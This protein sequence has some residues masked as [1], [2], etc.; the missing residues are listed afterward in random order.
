MSRRD[1][2][3]VCLVV[4]GLAQ[5]VGDLA[6]VPALKGLAAATCASPAPKVFSSVRGLETF[7]T[8]FTLEWDEPDGRPGA[9]VLTPEVYARLAGPYNRRNVYG[10]VLAYGP[11]LA[12]EPRTRP[13]FDAVLQHALCGA[14]PLATELGLDPARLHTHVRLLYEPRPGSD[15]GGLPRVLEACSR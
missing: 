1:F 3:A 14:R 12:T 15:M 6:G 4:L 8:R 9:L 7:S 2:A 5:M 10:A 11:A 13:M